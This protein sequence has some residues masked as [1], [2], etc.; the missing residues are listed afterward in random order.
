M[1]RLILGLLASISERRHKII[2][3]LKELQADVVPKTGLSRL[4]QFPDGS[5][6]F[7]DSDT[8]SVAV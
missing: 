6:I 8:Y 5:Y 7:D 4:V 3:F 1:A 2:D